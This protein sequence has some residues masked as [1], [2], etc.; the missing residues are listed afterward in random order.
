MAAAL[1]ERS[2]LRS[3]LMSTLMGGRNDNSVFLRFGPPAERSRAI[4][5]GQKPYGE[6]LEA[7]LSI[8]E[9]RRRLA[10]LVSGAFKAGSMQDLV[11]Y[12]RAN[13]LTLE[14]RSYA[15]EQRGT[16]HVRDGLTG[17]ST[18]AAMVHPVLSE[19]GVNRLAGRDVVGEAPPWP[20]PGGDALPRCPE[21]CLPWPAAG[22]PGLGVAQDRA[23]CGAERHDH[24]GLCGQQRGGLHRPPRW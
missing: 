16:L 12:L 21:G 19:R 13:L 9:V 15:G 23:A 11:G 24:A 6:P 2:S 8:K 20:D 14:S 1:A 10:D 4:A 5:N 7:G 18:P 17:R 3:S 22:L